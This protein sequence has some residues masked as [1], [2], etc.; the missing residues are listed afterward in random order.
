[1]GSNHLEKAYRSLVELSP[2]GYAILQNGRVIFCNTALTAISGYTS[3]ELM[4]MSAADV[5]DR[6]HPEDRDRTVATMA[7]RI[8]GGTPSPVQYQR[9][10]HRDGHYLW[11]ET[12]AARIDLDDGP[13]LQISYMNVDDRMKADAR[14]RESE[15]TL[16]SLI[17]QNIIGV[18]V[19]G[20]DNVITEWNRVMEQITGMP[21]QQVLGRTPKVLLGLLP[22]EGSPLGAAFGRLRETGPAEGPHVIEGRIRSADGV[23]KTLKLSI[24]SMSLPQ[25]MQF[26]GMA[27]DI[28]ARSRAE[29]AYR[30]LAE[31]FLEGVAIIQ[32]GRIV[33]CNPALLKLN[34]Y[35]LAE[36]YASTP[37]D[38][39][40]TVHQEDRPLVTRAIEEVLAGKGPRSAPQVRLFDRAGRLRWVEMQAMRTQ[41]NFRPALQVSY[42]DVTARH[43]ADYALRRSEER[44]RALI[45]NAPVAIGISRAGLMIYGNNAYRD[46]FGLE[47]GFDIAGRSLA[48]Q[49]SPRF[50]REVLDRALRRAQGE[51]A[52]VEFELVGMRRDGTQFPCMAAVTLIDLG[53]GPAAAAFF[54]DLSAMKEA[55]QKL[56]DSQSKLRNLAVHL[57]SARE[58]E[59][60]KVAREIHDELGQLLTAL[61]M[62]LRW[63]E[64][65]LGA[66]EAVVQEK[67]RQAVLLAD[68]T[69]QVVHRISAD[70]RPGPLDD[71]GLASAVDWVGAD[72]T[73]RTGIP[74]TVKVD[75]QES[76][77][78]GNSATAIFRL[79]QEA[80]TNVSR[81]ARA[82]HASIALREVLGRLEIVVR[83]DGVGI[84]QEQSASFSSFGLIGIRERVQDMGGQVSISGT[85]GEGTTVLAVIPLPP[86]GGLA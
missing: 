45:E 38:I 53:D 76:R 18:V 75:I 73:R 52:E 50:R 61:K 7:A 77:I 78:G 63:I 82:S 64:K 42:L 81:H 39:A 59:R 67:T 20:G 40:A 26:A 62:E 58:E 72:F 14:L 49:I 37:E 44:F 48:D 25:G 70:L 4:S 54:T 30:V 55:E 2:L 33:F 51:P 34:G 68:Q 8:E 43:D 12:I 11:V 46:L 31:N 66:S 1:V 6:M 13:A 19:V 24:F 86:L 71:L 47:R 69:L 15:T 83:D 79:V 35:T 29:E 32:D 28:T 57:L 56:K 80:L 3:E 60:K 22:A 5:I 10:R 27:E 85:P 16:R 36:V 23:L 21:R 84:T 65:K 41:Y 9:I 17:E 74:C